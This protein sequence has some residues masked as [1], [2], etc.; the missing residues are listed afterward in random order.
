MKKGIPVSK[1]F[2]LLIL[3]SILAGIVAAETSFSTGSYISVS[4]SASVQGTINETVSLTKSTI[5]GGLEKT[6]LRNSY[7]SV[8]PFGLSWRSHLTVNSD[9]E[10]IWVDYS[11]TGQLPWLSWKQFL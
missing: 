2:L 4:T 3:I 1:C 8:N 7:T 5:G 10:A 6:E 11:R 9:K